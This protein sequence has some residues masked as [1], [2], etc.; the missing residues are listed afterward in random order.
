M[1]IRINKEEMYIVISNVVFGLKKIGPISYLGFIQNRSEIILIRI[2]KP[3]F[4]QLV[5][6]K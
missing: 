3:V 4:I 2:P 5:F 1:M 6:R